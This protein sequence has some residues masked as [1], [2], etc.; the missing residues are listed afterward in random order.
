MENGK[1]WQAKA[2]IISAALILLIGIIDV[3]ATTK[4]FAN[5]YKGIL[6][7]IVGQQAYTSAI[8]AGIVWIVLTIGM[9]LLVKAITNKTHKKFIAIGVAAFVL[10]IAVLAIVQPFGNKA[11][12]REE[13]K[14]WFTANYGGSELAFQSYGVGDERQGKDKHI[15]TVFYTVDVPY[16]DFKDVAAS[17]YDL[18]SLFTTIRGI[19]ASISLSAKSRF[20]YDNIDVEVIV[21]SSDYTTNNKYV[22][23]LITDKPDSNPERYHSTFPL[24]FGYK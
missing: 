20:D 12:A 7:F 2:H 19:K 11:P 21:V 5:T 3:A 6:S 22:I 23:C 17:G 14:T 16:S 10:V 18:D 9:F 8:V 4:F 15:L 1:G 24:L 13:V